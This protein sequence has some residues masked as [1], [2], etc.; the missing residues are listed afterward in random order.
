MWA[1][2]AQRI[3]YAVP[4]AIGVTVICFCLVFLAPGDPVQMLLPPDASQADVEFLKKLYGFDQPIPV[5]YFKW[6]MRAVT[7]DLGTSL[8]TS[9]PVF[10]EVTRALSNTVI[11]S[12]GAVMLAFS[13]AFVFGTIAAYYVGR[14]IDRIVTGISVVGVSVPNYWLG[15]VLII[16]FAVELGVLPATGMGSKGS[17]DFTL[18]SW[19]QVKYAI[20]PIITLSMVPLGIIM[21]NTRA[22]VAEVLAHDFVQKIHGRGRP[23]AS[24]DADLESTLR[25]RQGLRDDVL[26]IDAMWIDDRHTHRADLRH[27]RNQLGQSG[28]DELRSLLSELGTGFAKRLRRV[29]ALL[30]VVQD[31]EVGVRKVALE[32]ALAAQVRRS[33]DADTAGGRKM[34]ADVGVKRIQHVR[35]GQRR[36][37]LQLTH[38]AVAGKAG[39]DDGPDASRGEAADHIE[40]A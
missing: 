27:E 22:A 3:L 21:R 28:N 26:R 13:L 12:F 18:A 33:Y 1:Y 5:Q 38:E 14:P 24:Q 6:L 39:N 20:L 34:A 36:V 10:D 40:E 32:R 31:L 2:T 35:D 9:R 8:Q 19:G 37:G 7:G 17:D 23:H 15:I 29:V 11:I 30:A 4:I 25:G 16:I